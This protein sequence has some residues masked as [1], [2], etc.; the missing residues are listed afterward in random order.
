MLYIIHKEC[1]PQWAWF[2]CGAFLAGT[3]NLGEMYAEHFWLEQQ[4]Q[5]YGLSL[6]LLVDSLTSW[7]SK[8]LSDGFPSSGQHSR[9]FSWTLQ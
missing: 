3:Q 8:A 1:T 9:I 2:G 4:I 5:S 7:V 6:Y